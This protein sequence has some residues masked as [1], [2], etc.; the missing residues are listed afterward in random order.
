MKNRMAMYE[1]ST[2]NLLNSICYITV[3]FSIKIPDPTS[4][5]GQKIRHLEKMKAVAF[6]INKEMFYL[7]NIA[8][9]SFQ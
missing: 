3:F 4:Q 7:L 9:V 8:F 1:I 6:S 2:I 5:R